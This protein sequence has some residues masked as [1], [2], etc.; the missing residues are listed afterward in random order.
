MVLEHL[1]ESESKIDPSGTSAVQADR[2]SQQDRVS[3][4]IEIVNF[5]QEQREEKGCRSN[6]QENH[7]LKSV[8]DQLDLCDL[9]FHATPCQHACRSLPDATSASRQKSQVDEETKATLFL[10]ALKLNY[11]VTAV[12]SNNRQVK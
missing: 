2:L 9:Q 11:S 10:L 7:D 3:R 12:L 1:V 5:L 8:H 6:I 4:R